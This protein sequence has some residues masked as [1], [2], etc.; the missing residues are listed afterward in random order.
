MDM[1]NPVLKAIFDRRSIRRFKSMPL[2]EEQIQTLAEVALASPSGSNRQPWVFHF[3]CNQDVILE[4]S[5]AAMRTYRK[6]DDKDV[7]D[8]MAKRHASIFYGAPL[9]IIVSLPDSGES[10]IPQID[11]GVAVANLAVAAQ[12]M[13]LSSCIIGLAR[14][15]F[16]GEQGKEMADRIKMSS[17]RKFAVSI[18][19]GYPDMDKEAH[20]R[21]PDRVIR[22][23]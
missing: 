23:D 5:D 10:K 21:R 22:I 7:L 11:A 4:I 9:V 16:T 19:I 17:D 2:T 14:A 3:L 18:A 15:A 6:N 1:D 8:R 20:D 13:G 12:G